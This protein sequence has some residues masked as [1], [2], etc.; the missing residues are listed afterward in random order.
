ML[1]PNFGYIWTEGS[2]VQVKQ[3][4]FLSARELDISKGLIGYATYLT[5]IFRD[6]MTVAKAQALPNLE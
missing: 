1:E 4:G 6:D 2:R 5:Q 3:A